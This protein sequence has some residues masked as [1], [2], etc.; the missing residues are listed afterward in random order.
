MTIDPEDIVRDD[1]VTTAQVAQAVADKIGHDYVTERSVAVFEDGDWHAYGAD[2]EY[3][4]HWYV[5]G[6]VIDIL[7]HEDGHT[8]DCDPEPEDNQDEIEYQQAMWELRHPE[9]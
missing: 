7:V 5:D 1:I 6:P 8:V 4:G 2:N 9:P 3:V